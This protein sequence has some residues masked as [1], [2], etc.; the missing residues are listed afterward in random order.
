MRLYQLQLSQNEQHIQSL[1]SRLQE[2]QERKAHI[3]QQLH[4]VMEAQWR[5]AIKIINNT[6]SPILPNSSDFSTI[7]QLNSLRS[8]SHLNLDQLLS[9]NTR[10]DQPVAE[11]KYR[12]SGVSNRPTNVDGLGS[13]SSVIDDNFRNLAYGAETPVTSK[14]EKS[15]KQEAEHELQKYIQLVSDSVDNV[16]EMLQCC[17]VSVVEQVIGVS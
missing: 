10:N 6:K 16:T 14:P 9:F 15:K 13:I 1:Q 11:V 5:E 2:Q 17:F 3:A 8:K 7:D 4:N 12:K